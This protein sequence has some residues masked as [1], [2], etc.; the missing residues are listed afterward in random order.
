VVNSFRIF[1]ASLVTA[2][3][4][5]TPKPKLML[6]RISVLGIGHMELGK[7]FVTSWKIMFIKLH[8]FNHKSLGLPTPLSQT[9]GGSFKGCL[10]VGPAEF[11]CMHLA[12]SEGMNV[13]L[14]LDRKIPSLLQP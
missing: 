7:R 6:R 4:S 2:K 8:R 3:K 10:V 9:G 1:W 13:P 12:I 14:R 11:C 5:P